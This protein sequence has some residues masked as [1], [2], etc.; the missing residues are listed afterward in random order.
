M[1]SMITKRVFVVIMA[2]ALVIALWP[3][4]A[5]VAFGEENAPAE[6][7]EGQTTEAEKEPPATE[8]ETQKE[9]PEESGTPDV[10]VTMQGK[11]QEA[12]AQLPKV[13]SKGRTTVV[14]EAKAGIEYTIDDGKSVQKAGSGA[15]TIAF[16]NLKPGTAYTVKNRTA[17]TTEADPSPWTDGTKVTTLAAPGKPVNATKK[18][19]KLNYS[20]IRAT[21]GQ[22]CLISLTGSKRGKLVKLKKAQK[23]IV[24]V[25]KAGKNKWKV[26]LLAPGSATLRIKAGGKTCKC[27]IKV[28]PY[29]IGKHDNRFFAHRG[30]ANS[31]PE[32]SRVALTKGMQAGFIGTNFD[33]WPSKPDRKG[34][35][36][37][38]V[39]HDNQLKDMTSS[40][41]LITGTTAGKILKMKVTK[42]NNARKYKQ[43]M[44]RLEDAIAITDKYKGYGQIEMKS[45]P[46]RPWTRKQTDELAKRLNKVAHPERYEVESMDAYSLR[47]FRDSKKKYPRLSGVKLNL[48]CGE[49]SGNTTS[50]AKACVKLGFDN[51]PTYYGKITKNVVK[52]C[53]SKGIG[54]SGYAHIN[55]D[56]NLVA[57]KMEVLDLDALILPSIPW[58]SGK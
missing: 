31:Y 48:V 43:K 14:I 6:T 40:K 25:K 17:G 30:M 56:S 2:F 13:Q 11:V 49:L 3:M 18:G 42:G 47:N 57:K 41:G 51:M 16:L 7:V 12:P 9:V 53:R 50:F 44:M 10:A 45:N 5:G 55:E 32:N 29:R 21:R 15:N 28:L 54:I 38:I 37:F 52:D 8:A 39:S 33:L 46:G 58:A 4:E 26:T 23:K 20:S 36:E 19:A 22:T 27:A 34:K 35:Y 24:A 1:R